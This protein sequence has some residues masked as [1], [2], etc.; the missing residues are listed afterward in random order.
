MIAIEY[1]TRL[2]DKQHLGGDTTAFYFARP[3]GFEFHAGQYIDI[4]LINPPEIDLDGSIRS[5]SI[6]SSP[7]E[8]HLL[9]VTRIRDTAFK[10]VLQDL[11]YDAE[12][13]L[14]GPYGSFTL[15]ANSYR[16]AV[17]M[18]G[19]I[20]I[21]PFLSMVC[22]AG[23]KKL[24]RNSYLFYSNPFPEEAAFLNTLQDLEKNSL[25]FR[26]VPTMTAMDESYESWSGETGSIGP[27]MLSKHLPSL[28]GPI[29]YLAGTPRFVADM[30]RM[31]KVAG[32][33]K[34]DVRCEEF[35]GY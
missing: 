31:L 11:P 15:H 33:D 27:E 7:S 17:F 22:S 18:A 28:Q 13:A 8:E 10:R 25:S 34:E 1:C 29:Y 21:T 2:K 9:I 5:F 19:G 32:V 12:I 30:L 6:A 35:I 24:A 16:P 26:F 20:G 3:P 14:D 23:R 4:T